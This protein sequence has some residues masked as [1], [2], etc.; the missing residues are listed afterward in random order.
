[1]TVKISANNAGD[2]LPPRPRPLRDTLWIRQ[3]AT[4]CRRRRFWRQDPAAGPDG[5]PHF[6]ETHPIFNE[7][8]S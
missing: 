4:A 5:A 3:M 7:E 6:P 1:M 2:A 8:A